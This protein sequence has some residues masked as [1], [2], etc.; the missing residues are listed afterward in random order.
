MRND[1]NSRLKT[2]FSWQFAQLMLLAFIFQV[3]LGQ[4]GFYIA[5]F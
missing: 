2:V 5:L 4:A 3:R 1:K